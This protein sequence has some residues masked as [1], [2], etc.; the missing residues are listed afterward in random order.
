MSV[1]TPAPV[2]SKNN[3]PV[4]RRRSDTGGGACSLRWWV[5]S[6]AF[7]ALLLA[8]ILL[9]SPAHVIDLS[10]GPASRVS[11]DRARKVVEQIREKQTDT[12]HQDLRALADVR[13]QMA[14][15]EAR[16]AA[17]FVEFSQE[18]AKDAP[19]KASEKMR[20]IALAQNKAV[21]AIDAADKTAD[22]YA[23]TF[24]G[25]YLDDIAESQ[26]SVAEA[27][28]EVIELQKK[29]QELLV[30][31][32][33]RFNAAAR[34]QEAATVAQESAEKAIADAAAAAEAAKKAPNS[35]RKLTPRQ[36]QIG[37]LASD[38]RRTESAISKAETNLADSKQKA[39]VAEA[40]YAKAKQ[41]ADKAAA[42]VATE[43]T[44]EVKAASEAAQATIVRAEK[45]LAS[46]RKKLE[47]LPKSIEAARQKLPELDSKLA[48][49]LAVPD[50][51]VAPPSPEDQKFLD[52][53]KKA[54][55]LQLAA[56]QGQ[57]SVAKAIAELG[58]VQAGATKG[59]PLAALAQ[60]AVSASSLTDPAPKTL[61]EAYESAVKIEDE[62]TQTY[63]RLRAIDLAMIRRIPLAEAARLTEVAKAIRPDLREGLEAPVESGQDAVA[64]RQAVQSARSEV[65]AMVR[66]ANS[67]LAQAKDLDR[68]QTGATVSSEDYK[69]RYEQFQ[70]M[71]QLA[72]EDQGGWAKDLSAAMQGTP[73][74]GGQGASGA[75]VGG[76]NSDAAGMGGIGG[77]GGARGQGAGGSG[78][79]GGAA[80]SSGTADVA[81][82]V[83]ASS[84]TQEN[85]GPGGFGSGGITGARGQ[86][87]KPEEIADR[88]IPTPGR[89]IAA[90]GPSSNWF[91]VD[92]WYILG[93]FDNQGR[94]NIE[95]K[96]PPETVIDLNA[97]YP[98][99]GGVPIRW[100]FYQS[101][102][103]F[104]Y[105]RMDA[106]NAAT[107]DPS[108]SPDAD[109]PR[110]QQYIIY[111][112]YSEVWFEKACDLWVAIGSDDFSKAWVE[113]QLVW[114]SGKQLKP[115]RMNEGVRK[116][117]F[118][119]G[120]NR[121]LFRVEN[122]RGPTRF[123]MVVSLVP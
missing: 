25:A 23:G 96:F 58:D 14:E 40:V 10:A 15:L 38:R 57:E 103:P 86:F 67:M 16:K 1:S 123:S 77:G 29:A 69:G 12:I 117:H 45:D 59:D 55:E 19:A 79:G 60:P 107:R 90:Q 44:D 27:Q 36:S 33:E 89:R 100:E 51:A 106:F 8:W 7:H 121:I 6:L 34:A 71:Q 31:G 109:A 62:L 46:A 74:S 49:L 94:K 93:P 81:N 99:K 92:S 24:A 108:L 17:E 75:G 48:K 9:F 80:W 111:Y 35:S 118:K 76:G 98:G 70:R 61:G 54:R 97:T 26:K 53:Q 120:V 73:G 63:R 5:A 52:L 21:E 84:E 43:N 91:Y 101:G 85:F 115:W 37:R 72:S 87:G 13:K 112:A 114:E 102:T 39:E 78:G 4:R 68:T 20:E 65:G 113:D 11:P 18:L 32:D 56:R 116:V 3:E 2:R 30:S 88:V 122:G 105:P 66:L 95:T 28:R 110:S 22:R 82:A 119:E 50:P 83:I 104:V 41:L 64:A 42:N 47:D